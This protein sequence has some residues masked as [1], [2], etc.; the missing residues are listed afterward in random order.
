V[1]RLAPLCFY[2]V[3]HALGRKRARLLFG[4][5]DFQCD[6]SERKFLPAHFNCDMVG[7]AEVIARHAALDDLNGAGAADTHGRVA[8]F[9]FPLLGFDWLQALSL[10]LAAQQRI[11]FPTYDAAPLLCQISTYSA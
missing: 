3:R 1:A 10:A 9:A 11:A 2:Q 7:I 6:K 8:L 4:L 5:G